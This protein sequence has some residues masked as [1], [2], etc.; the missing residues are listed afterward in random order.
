MKIIKWGLYSLLGVVFLLLIIITATYLI[1]ESHRNRV[2][3]IQESSLLIDYSEESIENGRHIA[4]IRGCTDC[5]GENLGGK[6]FIE[7]PIVGLFIA[8]NLTTG[9]GGIGSEYT[10]EDYVKAIRH[11]VNKQNKSV[12]FMP[13]HEYN[14]IDSND[15]ASLI[16]YIRSL[17]PVDNELPSSKINL[18]FRLMYLL[19][20]EI[21]LFPAQLIDHTL[22]VPE[23][24]LKRTPLELGSYVAAT[25]TGCHGAGFSGGKIPGVPPHWP[26]A[27]NLTPAGPLSSWTEA[28]FLH[29]MRTGITPDGRELVNEFMPW[30]VFGS[31][32]DEELQGL[33]TYLQS[34]TPAETG[35]R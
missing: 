7:D 19:D 34:L 1:T 8:S 27:S 31:M 13:S 35:S 17:D 25:C 14:Q 28:D 5:H 6:V 18:P 9:V 2:Y 32:T 24:P 20:S 22:P 4:T 23:S 29:A 30:Q 16:A 15:L 11:G 21:H 12:I 33:F 10:D 3:D 26:E